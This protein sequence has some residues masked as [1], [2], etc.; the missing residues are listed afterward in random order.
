MDNLRTFSIPA[1]RIG[2][3]I[4]W[5]S[6]L[7]IL[8]WL[9]TYPLIKVSKEFVLYELSMGCLVVYIVGKTTTLLFK[10]K[11]MKWENTHLLLL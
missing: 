2:K 10:Y 6:S 5:I 1:L 11:V 9:P 4:T 3:P 8:K 7:L